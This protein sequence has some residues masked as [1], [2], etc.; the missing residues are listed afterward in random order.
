ML[1]KMRAKQRSQ[2]ETLNHHVEFTTSDPSDLM[3]LH[4][5]DLVKRGLAELSFDQHTILV[6]HDLEDLPQ[7][8]IAGS[9]AEFFGKTGSL[10]M[11]KLPNNKLPN[12]D[13]KLAKSPSAASK[14]EF[15]SRDYGDGS[16]NSP[17]RI[18]AKLLRWG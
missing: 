4:D 5:Q 16:S 17:D 3:H 12:N 7:K 13:Q 10:I 6:L 1:I 2:Q 15:S 14:P 11:N 18:I 8:Q 9:D